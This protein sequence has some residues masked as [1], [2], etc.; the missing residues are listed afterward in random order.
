M[1]GTQNLGHFPHLLDGSRVLIWEE[2]VI[3]S[4]T[5]EV[6]GKGSTHTHTHTHTHTSIL[7]G[8]AETCT[9]GTTATGKAGALNRP[10]RDPSN[11][12]PSQAWRLTRSSET[13]PL[14]PTTGPLSI[15]YKQQG[16]AA[17]RAGRE[18]LN[19]LKHS[20]GPRAKT[21]SKTHE[22]KPFRKPASP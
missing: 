22:L 20:M 6:L 15:S 21:N 1:V 10:H 2:R 19:K 14:L 7:R 16:D 13:T 3:E 11:T 17:R 5:L 12:G 4:I 18:T 8:E 9:R